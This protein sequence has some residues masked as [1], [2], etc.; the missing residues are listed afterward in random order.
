MLPLPDNFLLLLFSTNPVLIAFYAFD[1]ENQVMSIRR[2][3]ESRGYSVSRLESHVRQWQLWKPLG[4][5]P[6]S[7][8]ISTKY[9]CGD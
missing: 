2:E 1:L 3:P 5:R 4:G 7:L 8:S 9:F 6:K